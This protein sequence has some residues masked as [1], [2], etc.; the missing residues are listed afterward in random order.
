MARRQSAIPSD[1]SAIRDSILCDIVVP[2][3]YEAESS[4]AVLED[5]STYW[6]NG[7][8]YVSLSIAGDNKA[9]PAEIY[10][11]LARIRHIVSLNQDKFTIVD[12]VDDI[13]A[14][15]KANR[16]AVGLNF[17]GSEP[18]GRDLA[19]VEAYYKLGIR[20]M[21]MAYNY[22]NNVGM[23]CL[24]GEA[25]NT[26]LSSFGK[27]LIAEMNRVGMIVDVA[28]CGHRTSMD[29]MATSTQ[30]CIFSHSNPR[31]LYDHPRNIQDDQIKTCAEM[32]GLIGIHGVGPFMGK[33]YEKEC[34][35]DAIVR[36]ID[37]VAQ[38]VGPRHIALG[39]D[40]SSPD[41]CK[42]MFDLGGSE[43]MGLPAELPWGF[44]DPSNISSVFS[45]LL[46]KGYQAD[47][48]KGLM[49]ENFLRIA[50]G[51]WR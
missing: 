36:N 14:A 47:D 16:L 34:N 41:Y 42:W 10:S 19:N 4:A 30:P 37:Y 44:F 25:S 32:G 13:R 45:Q 12:T 23:G 9:S 17:Q 26:G 50:S 33:E 5:I 46:D 27:R 11:K 38:L 15:K 35:A 6:R 2:P 43:K 48:V 18:V 8:S 24:E 21:L 28:H 1:L 40:Y 20:W 7:F 3:S 29:A 22:Q 49:G 39:L 51:I 31:A